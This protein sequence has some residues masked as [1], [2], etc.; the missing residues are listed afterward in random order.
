MDQAAVRKQ[1]PSLAF[2]AFC[3]LVPVFG[4]NLPDFTWLILAAIPCLVL[5]ARVMTPRE[6]RPVTAHDLGAIFFFLAA[7]GSLA[8][9]ASLRLTETALLWLA[10]CLAAYLLFRFAA[11]RGV[12]GL[13]AKLLVWAGCATVLYEIYRFCVFG[14]SAAPF[15]F[16]NFFNKN[17]YGGFL[18]SVIP[19]IFLSRGPANRIKTV[20]QAT[21]GTVVIA[22][23]VLSFSKGAWLAAALALAMTFVVHLTRR[24]YPALL[25]MVLALLIGLPLG[26]AV[27]RLANQAIISDWAVREGTPQ[28]VMSISVTPRFLYWQKALQIGLSAPVLGKG[29]G[30]FEATHLR[31][32]RWPIYSKFAHNYGVQLF[33]EL[34]GLGLLIFLCIIA[35]SALAWVRPKSEV[36]PDREARLPFY[37]AALILLAHS[38]LDFTMEVPEGALWFWLL[39]GLGCPAVLRTKGDSPGERPYLRLAVGLSGLVILLLAVFLQ[40]RQEAID[41][42]IAQAVAAQNPQTSVALF[43]RALRI[44]PY[45]EKLLAERASAYNRLGQLG[46]AMADYQAAAQADPNRPGFLMNQAY[47]LLRMGKGPEAQAA[48]EKALAFNSTLPDMLQG[49]ALVMIGTG[50]PEDGVPAL[51]KAILL[52]GPN[53]PIISPDTERQILGDFAG[54][55]GERGGRIRL[56]LAAV[57]HEAGRFEEAAR[58]IA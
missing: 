58:L 51:A 21:Y 13:A 38:C 12:L 2:A 27:D 39:F 44:R 17:I 54:E 47:L 34:G 49:Y 56:A 32:M 8:Y 25:A 5:L 42:L 19:L 46:K 41:G 30:T 57:E 53:L 22:G 37:L 29:Y 31:L 28:Y 14:N 3:V 33:A 45:D 24:A 1:L 52:Q 10:V 43:T 9:S 55:P 40:Y 16:W 36:D 23:L 20:L 50:R 6:Q 18:A 35:S 11:P 15:I 7:F 26:L 4:N 48:A